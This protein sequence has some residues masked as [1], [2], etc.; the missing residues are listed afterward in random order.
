ML[1]YDK[2]QV[3]FVD[4]YRQACKGVR[5]SV[6]WKTKVGSDETEKKKDTR[7]WF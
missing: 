5:K 4:E 6:L 3:K 7:G 2:S 1:I